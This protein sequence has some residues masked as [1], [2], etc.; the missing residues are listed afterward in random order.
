MKNNYNYE[1]LLQ[2]PKIRNMR[3]ENTGNKYKFHKHGSQV[4]FQTSVFELI[5]KEIV[6]TATNKA[7]HTDRDMWPFI[8]DALWNI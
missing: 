1:L 4:I 2:K 6:T 8:D 3:N 5:T 7:I